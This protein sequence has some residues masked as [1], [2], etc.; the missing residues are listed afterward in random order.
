MTRN[1][2]KKVLFFLPTYNDYSELGRIV[3]EITS[4]NLNAT[5]LIIDDG[6]ELPVNIDRKVLSTRLPVNLGLGI[7]TH[8]AV[9]F[10]QKY[11]FDYLIRIDSDGQHNISD[12]LKMVGALEHSDIAIGVRTNRDELK[13]FGGVLNKLARKYI[14]YLAR[15]TI[16]ANIPGDLNSGFIALNKASMLYINQLELERYPEPQIII[17]ALNSG[18]HI[19][20]VPT[21]QRKRNVGAST[22]NLYSSVTLLFR[23]TIYSILNLITGQK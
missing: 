6:S 19:T 18:L 5:I 22:L 7:A 21:K 20:E 16:R 11:K 4:L 10:S 17:S 1:T 14:Y 3:D 15:F 8:I 23:V 9:D 2:D 12:S 13:G